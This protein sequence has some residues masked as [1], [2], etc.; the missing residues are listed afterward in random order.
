[1]HKDTK[2]LTT[3]EWQKIQQTLTKGHEA[4]KEKL[5]EYKQAYFLE[6]KGI[7]YNCGFNT[8]LNA[9][10]SKALKTDINKSTV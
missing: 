5:W 7:L 3:K 6:I 8:A 1:M 10:E 9:Q 2:M 4:I